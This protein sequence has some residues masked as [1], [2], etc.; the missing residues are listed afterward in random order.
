[1]TIAEDYG[2][3][4][5]AWTEKEAPGLNEEYKRPFVRDLRFH[6]KVLQGLNRP[7]EAQKKLD[8]AATVN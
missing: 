5:I 3:K 1:L 6:A 7:E 4:G 8:E 2:R